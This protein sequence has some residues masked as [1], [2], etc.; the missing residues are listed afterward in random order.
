MTHPLRVAENCTPHPLH[1]AQN[2]MMHHLS[3]LAYPAPHPPPPYF[4]TSPLMR[5]SQRNKTSFEVLS[6]L[7]PRGSSEE[8][9]PLGGFFTVSLLQVDPHPDKIHFFLRCQES[10]YFTVYREFRA[11]IMKIKVAE[12]NAPINR[13]RENQRLQK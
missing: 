1:K 5:R 4:F 12:I 9:R 8:I 3:A 6:L 10:E 7:V 2:L 11:T 13:W